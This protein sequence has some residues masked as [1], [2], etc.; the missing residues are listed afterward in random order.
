MALSGQAWSS[1]AP[2]H[3]ARCFISCVV[4]SLGQCPFNQITPAGLTAPAGQDCA[5]FHE[6]WPRGSPQESSGSTWL[7]NSVLQ[8]S[9]LQNEHAAP[10]LPT[11]QREHY[12]TPSVEVPYRGQMLLTHHRSLPKAG[13][14]GGAKRTLAPPK[15]PL[16]PSNSKHGLEQSARQG[17]V[18]RPPSNRPPQGSLPTEA[19]WLA[20]CS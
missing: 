13:F 10:H 20:S 12:E 6:G 19:P 15:S 2:V 9:D 14:R 4:I 7:P 17:R 8:P 11:W 3:L 1:C 16:S 5:C 18:A